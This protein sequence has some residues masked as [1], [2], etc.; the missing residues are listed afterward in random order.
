MVNF[1]DIDTPTDTE[2]KIIEAANKIFLE[3]GKDGARMEEIAQEAGLN[4]ALLHYYFRSK[5]KLYQYIFKKKIQEFFYTLFNSF[6]PSDEPKIFIKDFIFNYIDLIQ[7]NPQVVRFIL[8][9]IGKGG[10]LIK[11]T[12]AELI[13]TRGENIPDILIKRIESAIKDNKIRKIDAQHLMFSLIGMS[14]FVFIA[15]PIVEIVFENVDVTDFKFIEA[16]KTTIFDLVWNGLK[17]S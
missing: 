9:E 3:Q 4:K 1:L 7:K 6:T 11:E 16:R 12:L 17:I 2:K 10:D 13:N 5:E 14:I 8:W 15:K